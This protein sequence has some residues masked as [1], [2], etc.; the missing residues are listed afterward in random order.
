MRRTVCPTTLKVRCDRSVEVV[1]GR[2]DKPGW[3]KMEEKRRRDP[4]ERERRSGSVAA[5]V[6]DLGPSV[7][8]RGYK[9]SWC[10]SR[11]ANMTGKGCVGSRVV[12]DIGWH[13]L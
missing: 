13:V 8:T 6:A 3:R 1:V 7:S 2:H 5:G 4:R 11:R 10:W 12:V 9:G